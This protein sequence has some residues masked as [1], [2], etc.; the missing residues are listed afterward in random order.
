[1]PDKPKTLVSKLNFFFKFTLNKACQLVV[2][3]KINIQVNELDKNV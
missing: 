2:T 3:K 1:M